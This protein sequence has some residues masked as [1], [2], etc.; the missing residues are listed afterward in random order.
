[1][2][3]KAEEAIKKAEEAKKAEAKKAEEEAAKKAAEEA[4]KADEAK[5]GSVPSPSYPSTPGDTT[6]PKI[7]AATVNGK[8]VTVTDGVYGTV[9]LSDSDKLTGGTISVSED[10]T[11]TITSIEG[12]DLT[13]FSSLSFTQSLTFGSNTLDFIAKIASFDKKGDGV[14]MIALARL[15]SGHNGLEVTGTLRDAA[16]NVSAVKLT[17][18]VGEIAP[19]PVPVP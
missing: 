17:F 14:S 9:G 10:S 3:K 18:I 12:I 13:G 11:L 19:V 1:M 7:T 15:D 6:A 5:K 16:G 8:N 4:K 2:L